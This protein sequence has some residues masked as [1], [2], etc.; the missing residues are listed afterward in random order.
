MLSLTH[1][2]LKGKSA[3]TVN[4]KRGKA[5]EPRHSRKR[6]NYLNTQV[7]EGKTLDFSVSG[8]VSTSWGKL[9]SKRKT[10]I[11]TFI[12]QFKL[13]ELCSSASLFSMTVSYIA[14]TVEK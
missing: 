10:R 11:K 12:N 6:G 13:A 3:Q 14:V 9:G 2:N 5:S 7:R 4:N 8:M 1:L